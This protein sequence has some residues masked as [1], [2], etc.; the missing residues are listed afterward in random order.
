[1][2]EAQRA[3]AKWTH[4]LPLLAHGPSRR[5][6]CSGGLSAR[7]TLAKKVA[8]LSGAASYG[9]G[10]RVVAIEYDEYRRYVTDYE[11]DRYLTVL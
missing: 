10:S 9:E 5:N 8:F 3:A 6:S 1:M 7:P 11:L 4:P 2:I